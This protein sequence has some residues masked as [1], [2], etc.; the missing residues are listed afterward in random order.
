MKTKIGFINLLMA[1]VLAFTAILGGVMPQQIVQAETAELFFSEYIE[2]S[3]FNKALEIFNGTEDI[4]DLTGY[5]VELYSNGSPTAS[6]TVSLS[7]SLA[8]DDVYVIAHGSA[9]QAILDVTD[10]ISNGVANFNGD[11][12]VVLKNGTTIIDV[13]GQIGIDPG[14]EW[15]SGLTSTADN[16]LRRKNAICAG[17]SNGSDAFDPAIEWDGYASDTFDGLGAHSA[18]CDLDPLEPKINEFVARPFGY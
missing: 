3:S 5:S 18:T 14:S 7:G 16:S 11:D 9:A 17:D 13:I 1:S 8:N 4:V 2:G 6:Q 12:A 10:L 15:G